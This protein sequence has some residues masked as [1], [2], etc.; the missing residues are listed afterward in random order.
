MVYSDKELFTD[1]MLIFKQHSDREW[2]LTDCVSF[3]TMRRYDVRTAFTFDVRFK[4][5]GFATIP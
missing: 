4:Q 1:G 3:A 5:A 2:S